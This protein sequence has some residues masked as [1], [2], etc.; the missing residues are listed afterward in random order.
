MTTEETKQPAVVLSTAMLER[1]NDLAEWFTD[2]PNHSDIKDGLCV[3]V[4]D[5][6][7]AERDACAKVA[8][9]TVCDTHIPTGINIYGTR[10]AAAIRTRSTT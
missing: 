5:V 4:R 1:I 10:A 2:N 8:A 6:A 9:K 3:L 7:F